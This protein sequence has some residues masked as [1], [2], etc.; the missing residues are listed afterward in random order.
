MWPRLVAMSSNTDNRM[1]TSTLP[2]LD[3]WLQARMAEEAAGLRTQVQGVRAELQGAQERYSGE[4]AALQGAASQAVAAQA[5]LREAEG[6][7]A[8]AQQLQSRVEAIELDRTAD[9][10]GSTGLTD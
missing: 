3:V 8:A 2:T 6:A 10:V 4:V 9:Q 7:L 5:Q 1:S